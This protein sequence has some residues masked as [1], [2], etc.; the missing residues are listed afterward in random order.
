MKFSRS[1]KDTNIE[2]FMA[3]TISRFIV[4]WWWQEFKKTERERENARLHFQLNPI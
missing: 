1:M 2:S 4:R 3:Q